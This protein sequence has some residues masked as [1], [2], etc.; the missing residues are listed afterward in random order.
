MSEDVQEAE[1]LQVGIRQLCPKVGY[2]L[3]PL[4]AA[5]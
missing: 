4:R 3:L 5:V 2:V 1:V